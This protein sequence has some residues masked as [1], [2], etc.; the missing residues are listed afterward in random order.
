[1]A[2]GGRGTVPQRA[3]AVGG[4]SGLAKLL[5]EHE[6][7]ARNGLVQCV[8]RSADNRSV[9]SLGVAFVLMVAGGLLAGSAATGMGSSLMFHRQDGSRISF[10]GAVRAWCDR[11]ALHVITLGAIGQSRW[12]L[13]VARTGLH[14]GQTINFT[15]RRPRG[16]ELFAFDATT[17]NEASEGA[18]GSRGQVVLWRTTCVRGGP[19]EIA[20]SAVIA[21]EFFDGKRI[22]ASGVVNG[23]IGARP[24]A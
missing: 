23:K 15:W 9:R 6:W 19:F 17:K 20:V 21:S 12:Q 24:H 8:A 18:E 16:I 10:P 13:S 22:R 11:D 14:S 4:G 2:Q 5:H 1:V 3:L 7:R